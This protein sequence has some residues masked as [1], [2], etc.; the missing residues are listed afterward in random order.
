MVRQLGV[1]EQVLEELEA[2]L[3]VRRVRVRARAHGL[4][5]LEQPAAQPARARLRQL[6]PAGTPLFDAMHSRVRVQSG[7]E[8]LQAN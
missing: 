7:Q 5:V 4:R 8:T 3:E 2:P 1:R 6:R